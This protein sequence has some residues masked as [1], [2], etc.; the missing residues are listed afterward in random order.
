[1]TS[2]PRRRYPNTKTLVG[3]LGAL[4]L[5]LFL[6]LS[7]LS[8]PAL[9][10]SNN[11]EEL[12]FVV[13][14]NQ[15][16]VSQGLQPLLLSD[17]LSDSS[18]KHSSD[19]GKYDFFD[20]YTAG[21]SD[22]FPL[23]A[24]PWDRMAA[25]GY[26]YNTTKG[27]NI[28]AGYSSAASVFAGWKSSPG[29]DENMRN[30]D[31]KVI[32][33]GFV[34]VAGSPYGYY[35]T[36][37]FGGYVDPTAHSAGG[38]SPPPPPADTE[39]PTVQLVAPL[40]GATVTGTV[41]IEINATDNVGVTRVELYV[42][43]SLGATTTS[44][45]YRFNW[46]TAGVIPGSYSLQARAY[47]AVGNVATDTISVS[48]ASTTTTVGPTTTTT[49]ATTMTTMPPVTTTTSVPVTTTNPPP[50][51]TTTTAR[52]IT[53][54][55]TISPEPAFSDVN[56]NTLYSAAILDLASR[57]VVTGY[58][59]GAFGPY[60]GV[61]RQQFAKMIVLALG[62]P[63]PASA[64][65]A[66]EDVQQSLDPRDPMY[67]QTY[68]AVA[69]EHAITEGET[70][71]TFGPYDSVTR[72]QLIT[73]VARAANLAEPPAYYVPPFG[74]FSADHYPWARKAAFAGLLSGLQGIGPGYAFWAPATR[75]EVCQMLYNL[76]HR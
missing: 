23:N 36:T 15:Y 50:Q 35:W 72:A 66:F 33:V 53:T 8:G 32:G 44:S 52:P 3:L 6:S 40:N 62:Y 47:D 46:N 65:C 10:T 39:S 67:P 29:H 41:S 16:R 37:D 60:D 51:T 68:V 7:L 42:N 64:P 17:L 11:S 48:I 19:M 58:G 56:A 43:G 34:N 76:E 28:A 18:Q 57:G 2:S 20:H 1:M 31:F 24:S 75:G 22:F 25:C 55:T 12:A 73:M 4:I 38:S 49:Y 14:I 9:A 30:A 71:D 45:P 70:P 74:D 59:D 54:S 21:G 27:E 61:T 5:A 13:L 69:A 63:L 26:N